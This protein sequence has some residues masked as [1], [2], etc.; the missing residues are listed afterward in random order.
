MK[1][2]RWFHREQADPALVIKPPVYRFTGADEGL[3]A[4]TAVRRDAADSIRRRA[5]AVETGASVGQVLK[6]AK[7]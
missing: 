3:A 2:W 5:S 6:M 7:R 1:F 4:R